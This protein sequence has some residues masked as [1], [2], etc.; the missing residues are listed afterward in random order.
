MTG[1]RRIGRIVFGTVL[2]TLATTS[3]AHADPPAPGD[4]RSEVVGVEPSSDGFTAR[5]IGGDSFLEITADE[6]VE[7]AVPGYRD[8][9]YLRFEAD[10]SVFE[11]QSSPTYFI[12]A[13]R[14]G[15]ST[16]ADIGPDTPPDWV[17]VASDGSFA[18]HD[19]RTH[20]MSPT[21]P[22]GAEPGDEIVRDVV[23][24][25]VDGAR[26]EITVVSVWVPA[27]APFA[28]AGGLIVGAVLLAVL[29][30]S[31]SRTLLLGAATGLGIAAL[32][33]G[34][35]EFRSL[36][37]ETGRSV[38]LWLL[39]ATALLAV[40][41]AALFGRRFGWV[42]ERGL[43][44]VAGVQLT[45]WA[46]RRSSALVSSVLPTDLPWWL[47][48]FVSAAVLVGAPALTIAAVWPIVTAVARPQRE[49]VSV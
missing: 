43:V 7:I 34:V 48:R 20:W 16:P 18:W 32:A 13:S 26:V 6:G 9:P 15:S 10:G 38:T 39:P 31:R 17:Q 3:V 44:A 2:C 24:I 14:F 42:L 28:V 23:P 45:I 30:T 36:P 40:A 33:V 47:D 4:F 21:P 29:L 5:I 11:N 35:G 1:L 41:I 46:F 37:A 27:P 8:E 22:A 49:P 19:H 25:T 12:N